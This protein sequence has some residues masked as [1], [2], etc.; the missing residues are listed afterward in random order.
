MSFI[1]S[2]ERNGLFNLTRLLALI[3]IFL[4]IIGMTLGGFF[5][6][7]RW[8]NQ[9]TSHIN[10][11]QIADVVKPDLPTE[12]DTPEQKDNLDLDQRA[13]SNIPIPFALQKYF[14]APDNRQVLLKN[15][16]KIPEVYRQDY[17]ENMLEII[18]AGEK[19]GLSTYEVLNTYMEMKANALE[20]LSIKEPQE[21]LMLVY[22]SGAYISA[23]VLMALFS[24]VLVLLAIERNTRP[25]TQNTEGKRNEPYL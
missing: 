9:P 25:R 3:I 15:L 7:E 14:S 5:A 21:K 13:S 22:I 1:N 18:V 19:S 8:R 6:F 17:L 16:E 11:K 12:N 2:F 20:E 4:L 23:L 10:Y 24:L